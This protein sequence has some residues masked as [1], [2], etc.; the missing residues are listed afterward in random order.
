MTYAVMQTGLEPPSAEQ[1]KNAFQEVPGLTAMNVNTLGKDAYGV[2]VKGFEFDRASAMQSALAAQGVETEVVDDAALTELPPPRPLTKVEFTPEAL[3]IYDL[4]GQSVPLEWNNISVIASGRTRLTEFT[5]DLVNKVVTRPAGRHFELKV[6]TE[7]V[8]KEAQQDHLLLEIVTRG[9]AL[10]YHAVADR[11]EAHLLFQSL[12]ERRGKDPA[13]NLALFVQD[14]AKFA[15]AAV[16][17]HGAFYMCEHSDPLYTYP[18]Q[19]AFYREITWLLWMVSTG[20][21]KG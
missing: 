9:A 17:N 19:T 14:L 18:S 4:L 1:L 12:G 16:L 5:R 2:L 11:I 10:R 8:T 3:G 6:V 20:R 15:P 13:T 7:A 21:A